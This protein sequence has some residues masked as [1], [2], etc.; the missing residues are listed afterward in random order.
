MEYGA[1]RIRVVVFRQDHLFLRI[2]AADGRTVAVAAL[3][4]LPRADA[5]DPGD[6]VGVL[7]VGGAQY[8][9]LVGARGA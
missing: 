7:L 4:D 2:G 9:A 6:L 1:L 8:L 5:L 3:D